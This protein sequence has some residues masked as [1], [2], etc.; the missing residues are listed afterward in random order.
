MRSPLVF[1][2]DNS[3]IVIGDLLAIVRR[4]SNIALVRTR[5]MPNHSRS[6]H[7]PENLCVIRVLTLDRCQHKTLS[8]T[9]I[10]AQRLLALS[11]L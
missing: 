9:I 7:I 5:I 1:I 3:V 11:A 8:T 4:R 10:L 2:A 6:S